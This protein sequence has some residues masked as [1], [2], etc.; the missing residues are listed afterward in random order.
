MKNLWSERSCLT[1]VSSCRLRVS[2]FGRLRYPNLIPSWP[3]LLWAA[4]E[5]P[6]RALIGM[7]LI[8]CA[9]DGEESGYGCP[10]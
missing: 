10:Y 2:C 6:T 5:T 9:V 8:G 7:A 4:A 3:R 1:S